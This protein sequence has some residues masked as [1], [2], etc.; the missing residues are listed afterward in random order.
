[1][2]ANE[3]YIA[4]HADVAPAELALRL[5][6]HAELDAAYILRQVEGRQILR[7]KVPEWVACDGLRYP[8]RLALEQCSA[9][10][11]ARYKAALARRLV[12]G[13]ERPTLVDLTGGLGVDFSF[14]APA[15]ARA[16]YV[17]RQAEL[18]RLARHNLPLLGLPEADV[19]Q[20]DAEDYL[21]RMPRATLVFLD[22]ARRGTAGER[23]RHIA[24]CQP[25]VSALLPLLRERADH[26][27]VKLAPM[28][29]IEEALRTLDS[30]AEVHVVSDG[31]ECKE[32]LLVLAPTAAPEPR[33]TCAEGTTTLSFTRGE[34]GAARAPLTAQ[35][36]RY[37]YEP[38]P[39]VL[40][41]GAF[42]TI[43]R[44]YHLR[45]LHPNSHLYTAPA[46]VDAFP[47]RCFEVLRQTGFAKAEIRGF[48]G[49][50]RRA[51]L[52]VRNFPMT[53]ASLRRRLRVAEGGE[54]Y[55][56]AT[57]LADGTHRLIACRK[58]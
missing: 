41:A 18:V 54:E 13:V 45:K 19:V 7:R 16:T 48:I 31:K 20:A 52:A 14:M 50:T 36:A 32:L 5:E 35:L 6:R 33:I 42:R 27:L 2:N 58:I 37:L 10:P 38:G 15:F 53:V 49:A 1:M 3:E 9:A 25:D 24:D 30:V 8:P 43:A 22:P 29:D 23:L 51:N 34:E 40:K 28:L 55:W 57:T 4:R 12:A 46:R 47:G 17:E 44:R 39:A 11:A 56:F 21:R 26:C